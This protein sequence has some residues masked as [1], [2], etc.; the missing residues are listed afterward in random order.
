MEGKESEQNLS[1]DPG[2]DSTVVF[3]PGT[4]DSLMRNQKGHFNSNKKEHNQQVNNG[5]EDMNALTVL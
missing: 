1:D 2:I 5:Q 4:E 3:L